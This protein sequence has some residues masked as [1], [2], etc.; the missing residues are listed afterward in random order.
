MALFDY[1][2]CILDALDVGETTHN[3]LLESTGL[4]GRPWHRKE[5]F[6]LLRCLFA[7]QSLAPFDGVKVNAFLGHLIKRTQ[8]PQAFH[9]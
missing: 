1:Y 3:N 7:V 8:L 4:Y 9:A 2:V 6:S 5:Y